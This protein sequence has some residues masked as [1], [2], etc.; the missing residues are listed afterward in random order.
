MVVDYQN[1]KIYKLV[2]DDLDKPIYVGH[3]AQK[4]LS[5]RMKSHRNNFKQ[6]K[7]GKKNKLAYFTDDLDIDNVQIVLIENYPCN[8]VSEARG[9]ELYWKQ[10]YNTRQR[11]PQPIKVIGGAVEWQKEYYK[12]NKDEICNRVKQYSLGHKEQIQEL[13]KKYRKSHK[14]EI[15]AKKSALK[16]C[17]LCGKFI[18]SCHLA[19]H[20]RENCPKR[21]DNE[22]V[23]DD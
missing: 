17:N 11:N 4:Y 5:D 1:T 3:T 20:K 9:R 10:F 22:L 7:N 2:L 8:D 16:E 23:L 18:T 12:L 14:E 15:K 21:F 6:W 13:S 19:R